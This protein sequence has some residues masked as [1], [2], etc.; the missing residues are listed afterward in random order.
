MGRYQVLG[1]MAAVIAC[2]A[3]LGVVLK[4][5]SLSRNLWLYRLNYYLHACPRR[6]IEIHTLEHWTVVEAEIRQ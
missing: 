4:R 5:H 6:I 1:G 3:G 2:G